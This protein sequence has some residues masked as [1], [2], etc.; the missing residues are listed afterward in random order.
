[1]DIPPYNPALDHLLPDLSVQTVRLVLRPYETADFDVW[2]I[3]HQ[4]SDPKRHRFDSLADRHPL[5]LTQVAF[6]IMVEAARKL[7]Q[8]DRHYLFGC[9]EKATG[10][11][12]GSVC[13]FVFAR[14]DWQWANRGYEFHNQ[15]WGMGYGTEAGIGVLQVGFERL[16]LHR[17]EAA[18]DP[19]NH[20]AI[21]V[22]L[23]NGMRHEG[24]RRN[25]IRTERGEWSD[26]AIYAA[27]RDGAS[28]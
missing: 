21:K 14:G 8:Q 16:G 24:T 17:I 25:F 28:K 23:K 3:A 27:T 7:R 15:Y 26:C 20:A 13:L 12:V 11:H 18:I 9:F 6:E 22:A 4:S 1:M 19:D 10:A 5:E 2:R